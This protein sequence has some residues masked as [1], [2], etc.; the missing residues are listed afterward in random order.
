M[1]VKAREIISIWTKRRVLLFPLF[2]RHHLIAHTY[3]T[4]RALP[5][6]QN[7]PV[8]TGHLQNEK[9]VF[10]LKFSLKP[11]SFVHTR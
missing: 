2:T 10:F 5:Q 1:M 7:W 11:I 6:G 9:V 4:L 3:Q 8:R